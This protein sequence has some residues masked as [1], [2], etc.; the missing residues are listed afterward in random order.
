MR[1]E[2]L[3]VKDVP[4]NVVADGRARYDRWLLARTDAREVGA[5]PS[6]RTAPVR[7]IIEEQSPVPADLQLIDLRGGTR[8]DRPG[9]QSF[10]LLVHE[11]LA[12][13]PFD[14]NTDALAELAQLH[15]R[16][17]GLP[18][19]DA[20]SAATVVRR[21]LNHDLWNRARAA[22]VRG[23]CRRETPVT[24]AL[25]DGTLAEGIV[26]LAFE[27]NGTWTVVDYK[28]DRE[29]ASVGEE[30]YRRQVAL[31]ASAIARATG[32]PAVPVLVRI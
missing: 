14:A 4:R 19:A 15:A 23:A 28:S 3:I 21:V 25:D 22:H 29:F 31:Y 16:L 7:E 26:D 13:A 18:G 12:R 2:D 5:Q 17:L 27:Q 6:V 24:I 20:D 10:G 1:R 11:L 8:E 32:Q 9:G 30:K